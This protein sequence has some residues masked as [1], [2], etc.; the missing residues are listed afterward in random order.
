ML[1]DTSTDDKELEVIAKLRLIALHQMRKTGYTAQFRTLQKT[2]VADGLF[3]DQSVIERFDK[4]L[5]TDE[6]DLDPDQLEEFIK[7]CTVKIKHNLIDH[8]RRK[9]ADKRGGGN[10]HFSFDETF[11]IF[12]SV[13]LQ[14][15]RAEELD[16]ALQALQSEFHYHAEL[17]EL[18]Y[19]LGMTNREIAEYFDVSLSKV[20]KDAHFAIAWLRRFLMV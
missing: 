16:D 13:R 5:S 18:K 2:E 8:M 9:S 1:Q 7:F 3:E 14:P 17:V 12:S 6:D 10:P 11:E 15:A 19:F 4:L 20:E